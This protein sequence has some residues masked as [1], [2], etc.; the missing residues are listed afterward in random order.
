MVKVASDF[1]TIAD[2]LDKKNQKVRD[3]VLKSLLSVLDIFTNIPLNDED[4]EKWIQSVAYFK[5][6]V[7]ENRK[8]LYKVREQVQMWG[9]YEQKQIESKKRLVTCLDFLLETFNM[10][11]KKS[12]EIIY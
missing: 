5:S 2:Y 3:S 10:G 6:V 8:E 9:D 11:I 1:D 4:K 7:E 12:L